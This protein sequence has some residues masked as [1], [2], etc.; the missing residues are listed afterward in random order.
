MQESHSNKN[1]QSL[2]KYFDIKRKLIVLSLSLLIAG[3]IILPKT[4][5]KTYADS[6][7]CT[8]SNSVVNHI[9]H[10]TCAHE[11]ERTIKC[12][13]CDKIVDV[14]KIEK[15]PHAHVQT[16]VEKEANCI[17]T[18]ITK[19]ICTDC[20]TVIKETVTPKT[21]HK[22]FAD[23]V[24]IQN[25]CQQEGVIETICADCGAVVN[26]RKTPITDHAW[27][28]W[29]ITNYAQ[30]G[31]TG[32]KER[33]CTTCSLSETQTYSFELRNNS[34]YVNG[35]FNNSLAL[36]SYTQAC[37]DANDIVYTRLYGGPVIVGHNYRSLGTLYR[38]RVGQIIYIN[39]NNQLSKYQVFLSEPALT[40][41]LDITS[42]YSHTNL[43]D[44]AYQ[45]VL[46]MY[47]CYDYSANADKWMVM[48]RRIG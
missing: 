1:N 42:N 38:V 12:L 18:G 43:S 47:T 28:N 36:G 31:G 26:S 3:I 41:A 16:I 27:S 39:V 34:F 2:I 19:E 22:H 25:N 48:A 5:Q 45:D 11:G 35:I 7:E 8:H 37:L 33:H 40:S 30:P 21:E 23:R 44:Y 15:L 46:R 4:I 10:S 13:D 29:A 32:T 14:V 17:T 24:A 20:N 6:P 9:M